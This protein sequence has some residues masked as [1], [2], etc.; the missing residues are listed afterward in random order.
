MVSIVSSAANAIR[1]LVTFVERSTEVHPQHC[2]I[3]N[4][5]IENPHRVELKLKI[6]ENKT[7]D[8]VSPSTSSVL[9]E[10]AMTPHARTTQHKAECDKKQTPC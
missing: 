8:S 2:M 7:E 9:D 3:T 1:R 6:V 10:V 4:N 5:S